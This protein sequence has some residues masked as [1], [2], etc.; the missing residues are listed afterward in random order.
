MNEIQCPLCGSSVSH[1]LYE[2]TAREAAEHMTGSSLNQKLVDATSQAI[3]EMWGKENASYH[4]CDKCTLVFGSPFKAATKEVYAASYSGQ[5]YYET[6]KWEYQVSLERIK[7][8]IGKTKPEDICLL[9][10]GAGN[11]A[12]V[13]KIAGTIIPPGNILTTE[14]SEYG[15]KIIRS[16][17]I[18]CVA[19]GIEEL[20]SLERINP[21]SILCLF[22]VLEHLENPVESLRILASLAAPGASLFIAIPN[23]HHRKVYD[24]AGVHYDLPPIHIT[25]WNRKSM[26]FLA[27]TTG[28]EIMD[29][30][31][32]PQ[33]VILRLRFFLKERYQASKLKPIAERISSKLLKIPVIF[34]FLGITAVLNLISVLKLIF[35]QTGVAQWFELKK[36]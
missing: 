29:H 25:R 28:W 13:G 30:K 3:I 20:S 9:E 18:N 1:L 27:A 32:Q 14:Y 12:F 7:T 31:F 26:E 8:V 4:Q 5:N 6:W 22:Q 24:A 33:P 36:I 19:A 17:G 34:F 11:G 15:R 21:F 35:G 10:I 23:D 16:L 2:S